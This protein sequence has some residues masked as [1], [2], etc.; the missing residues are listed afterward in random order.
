[1]FEPFRNY[2]LYHFTTIG[3][4]MEVKTGYLGF[5]VLIWVLRQK[6]K[7]KG[8]G[9]FVLPSFRQKGTV[10]LSCPHWTL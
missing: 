7:T 5:G 1:M 10:H 2:L 3:S 9:S 4:T 8:D 6:G